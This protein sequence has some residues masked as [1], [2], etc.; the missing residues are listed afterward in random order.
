MRP[1]TLA[2][3]CRRAQ[4][5][6]PFTWAFAKAM[7]EF[8]QT[9]YCAPGPAEREPMLHDEPPHFVD[10]RYDALVGGMV[11]YFYKRWAPFR[12]PPWIKNRD[13]SLDLPF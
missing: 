12:P 10:H 9:Y 8:L 5:G 7:G 11:E 1:T 3:A 4:T 13:R 6:E 2:E